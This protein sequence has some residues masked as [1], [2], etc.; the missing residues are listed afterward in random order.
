MTEGDWVEMR[1]GCDSLKAFNDLEGEVRK[2][3]DTCNYSSEPP[4]CRAERMWD[5]DRF[6][7]I[8]VYE[9]DRQRAYCSHVPTHGLLVAHRNI[10]DGDGG[11]IRWERVVVE[12]RWDSTHDTCILTIDGQKA[13]AETVGRWM[14]EAMLSL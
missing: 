2:A 4:S 7:V 3:V 14:L 9:N 12:V 10:V 11:F 6:E 5:S 1:L 8:R 13:T